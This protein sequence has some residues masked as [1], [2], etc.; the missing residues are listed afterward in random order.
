[1]KK[2]KKIEPRIIS[3]KGD[4]LFQD[5]GCATIF[6][7]FN[8]L[9]HDSRSAKQFFGEKTGDIPWVFTYEV[10]P[11]GDK[12][13]FLEC[14]NDIVPFKD[15]NWSKWEKK[16][17]PEDIDTMINTAAGA[18]IAAYVVGVRD[19][20]WDNIC[21]KDNRILFHIDFGFLL[22]SQPPI[23]APL[24][25]ISKAMMI[26][27]KNLK[28]WDLFVEKILNAFLMLRSK[29]EEVI[30]AC[31]I[32]F[33]QAGWDPKSIKSYLSSKDS[34]MLDIK[35][36]DK[37]KVMLKK[38]IETSPSSWQNLFKQFSHKRVDPVWYGLLK[39]HF[40]PASMAMK[41][42]EKKEEKKQQKLKVTS[43]FP[44]HSQKVIVD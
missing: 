36:D 3:K 11:T 10:V 6:R 30:T 34:L 35:E 43:A 29:S 33:G 27:L 8:M 13:G 2:L 28:K 15:F 31:S 41:V 5:L 22:G 12:M 40:P 32:V 19:R 37:A 44:K 39:K 7:V 20:H 9:W 14:V 4:N 26:C 18:H 21:I 42:V 25:S 24:F 16:A 23:D 38:M 17:T 1:V